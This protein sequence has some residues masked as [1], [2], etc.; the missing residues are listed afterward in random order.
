M[1]IVALAAGYLQ[2]WRRTGIADEPQSQ[3]ELTAAATLA[4][5]ARP[6]DFVVSDLPVSAVLADR[7]VPG[8][9]V[10]AA[11]L[12]FETGSLTPESALADIDRWCVTAVVAGR[13]FTRQP[14]L[15]RGLTE[16]FA[17][18]TNES[19]TTVYSKPS[20]TLHTRALRAPGDLRS[21]VEV[22][23]QR[24]WNRVP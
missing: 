23:E 9:L 12:R 14:E 19:G 4:R 1:L 16:R 11:F 22:R 7:P 6:G 13:S 21:H 17:D 3:A 15:L 10:D 20:S 24:P 18:A 5:V 2:Q 8:P